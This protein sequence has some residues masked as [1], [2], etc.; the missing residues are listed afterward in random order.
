[1]CCVF[2]VVILGLVVAIMIVALKPWASVERVE[3]VEEMDGW[4]GEISA[5]T[6]SAVFD[7]DIEEKLGTDPNYTMDDALRDYENAYAQATGELKF[8]VAVK[9]A[10][11]VFYYLDDVS[12][13]TEILEG[14]KDIAK[15]DVQYLSIFYNT[16]Y[17][18]YEE[19]GDSERAEYY[20]GLLDEVME[21][22]W[23]E[24][25]NNE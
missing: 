22:Y 1:M 23:D 13:A 24:E 17:K 19:Y 16:L 4:D 10:Q 15:S 20:K 14:V 8:Q 5:S 12:L 21:R 6:Q 7:Y 2:G 9:Y 25:V 11:F 18:I 3:I